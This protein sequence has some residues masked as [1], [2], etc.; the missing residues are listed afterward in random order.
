MLVG[1]AVVLLRLTSPRC[2]GL[3]E[4]A[5][6]HPRVTPTAHRCL[7]LWRLVEFSPTS[8]AMV[9]QTA[10]S[11][12]DTVPAW[13]SCLFRSTQILFLLQTLRGRAGLRRSRRSVA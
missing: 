8:I 1:L 10:V 9:V 6:H 11:A 12:E 3:C 13:T 5:L 4:L 2:Q 7:T